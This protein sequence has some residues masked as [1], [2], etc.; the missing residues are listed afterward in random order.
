MADEPDVDVDEL[1]VETGDQPEPD[2]QDEPAGE[3]D[4][5]PGD[6]EP[7]AAAAGDTGGEPAEPP[8][9][10]TERQPTGRAERRITAQ[11]EELRK[12][13]QQIADLNKRLDTYLANSAQP[14]QPQETP[15]QREQRLALLD[16]VERMRVEMQES[17]QLSQRQMAAMSFQLQD[18]S[19]KATYDA[20]ALV[21]P[22]YSK[23]ASKVE[24]ELAALRAKGQ[25]VGRE[26]MLKY[27]IGDA[28]LS[29]RK[30]Q[31][32]QQRKAAAG[33]MARNRTN[34]GNSRSDTA[35]ERRGGSDSNALEKRLE[36]I[37]I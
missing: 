15:E 19:D 9:R 23:W 6:D 33:R 17:Q 5:E 28:A 24:S 36:N 1:E 18:T 27:L 20:K 13:D 32:Q 35:G 22:L 2:D 34:P 37:N 7:D 29:G 11:Q 8:A 10:S 30:P 25:N 26:Q 12:R 3:T 31:G 4:D 21:D 14:R 16:P